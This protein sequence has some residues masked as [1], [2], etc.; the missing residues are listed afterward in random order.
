M[1]EDSELQFSLLMSLPSLIV[2]F[3]EYDIFCL[4]TDLKRLLEGKHSI[5]GKPITVTRQRPL[6]RLPPDPVR[7]HIQGLS[8]KTTKDCLSFYLEKFSGN[9][10]VTKVFFGANNNALVVFDAPP[11]K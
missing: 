8:E 2:C 7:I 5:D 10:L 6:K 4:L 3:N 1:L 9:A 11:G